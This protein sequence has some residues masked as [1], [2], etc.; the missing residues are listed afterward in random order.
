[1][2]KR[3]YGDFE[4]PPARPPEQRV[5]EFRQ[6]VKALNAQFA[7]WVERNKSDNGD[8]LWDSGLRDYLKYAAKVRAEFKDVLVATGSSDPDLPAGMIYMMG[9]VLLRVPFRLPFLSIPPAHV[10]WAPGVLARESGV[11]AV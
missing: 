8:K 11:F 4:N 6:E 10:A 1:M 9:Q 3:D 7:S 2:P 5:E